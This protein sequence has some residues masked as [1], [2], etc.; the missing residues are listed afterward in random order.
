M[1]FFLCVIECLCFVN[2]MFGQILFNWCFQFDGGE[3]VICFNYVFFNVDG[4]LFELDKND[5]IVLCGGVNIQVVML[6]CLLLWLCC[7]VC[8]GLLIMGLCIVSYVFV[9]VGLLDEKWVIIY[10]EN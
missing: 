5:V 9:C 6:K 8:K 7:E 10:W 4:D 1:I 2:W 3:V